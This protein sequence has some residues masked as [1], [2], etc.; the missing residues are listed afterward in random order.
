M[1]ILV[2][3][4]GPNRER[5]NNKTARASGKRFGTIQ[6][7]GIGFDLMHKSLKSVCW[8]QRKKRLLLIHIWPTRAVPFKNSLTI[9]FNHF[10]LQRGRKTVASDS[11][12]KRS[13]RRR[14]LPPLCSLVCCAPG[15][16]CSRRSM[17]GTEPRTRTAIVRSLSECIVASSRFFFG[18]PVIELLVIYMNSSPSLHIKWKLTNQTTVR[19]NEIRNQTGLRTINRYESTGSCIKRYSLEFLAIFFM[20][21]RD[22]GHFHIC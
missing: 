7:Q 22:F 15:H 12:R 10:R 17:T 21:F 4:L 18:R 20:I 9:S 11:R 14:T 8:L 19:F 16:N 13:V 3:I 5:R 6:W 1:Q 2:L